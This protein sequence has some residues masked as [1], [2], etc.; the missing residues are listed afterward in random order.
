M[1]TGQVVAVLGAQWGDE[2]KGKIVDIV[3]SEFG[4]CARFNGGSNAGHTIVVNGCKYAFHLLPSGILH[5]TCIALLGNGVV[6]HIPT[7]LVELKQLEGKVNYQNRFKISDRAHIV[8]DF[9][10]TIDGLN[11]TSLGDNKIGTTRKG[12]GPCYSS[13]MQRLGIRIGDLL[14]FEVFEKK[15]RKLVANSQREWSSQLNDINIESE[16][17]RYREYATILNPFIC[18]SIELITRAH[19]AGTRILL[20]G[21]NATLLDIDFGTYPYVT[22]SNTVIGGAITGLGLSP[23]KINNIIA[24]VKA[25]TTRV[26]EGPFPS[27]LNDE[28]GNRLRT[29]GHEFGTTTG[30]PRRCGWL[31]LVILR[32]S[33]ALNGFSHINLTK[34]DV[35]SGLSEIKIATS[36]YDPITKRELEF[37]PASLNILER[38]E[39]KYITMPGWNEDLSKCTTYQSLP[40]N[41][42]AYIEKIEEILNLPIVWIGVSPNREGTIIK[43]QQ[44]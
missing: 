31:D 39:V 33:N 24:V 12:I 11:E 30:R 37:I 1:A 42:R 40:V 26:G 21:A 44:H 27:E 20:E 28:I 18:D 35:L 41:A 43:Q 19:T 4:I 36:Y 38:V 23:N 9:H 2:G 10:Q 14:E 29:I 25:Y 22:S 17:Q 7:L 32:F 34:L 13:K 5:E 15:F 3:G 6:V 8:F 16:L